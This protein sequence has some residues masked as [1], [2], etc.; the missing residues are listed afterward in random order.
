M[1]SGCSE[2]LSQIPDD[3]GAPKATC[4]AGAFCL[5]VRGTAPPMTRL[6]IVWSPLAA[7]TPPQVAW[8]M[9]LAGGPHVKVQV[10]QIGPPSP[11]RTSC[12]RDC[13]DPARCPCTTPSGI[14]VGYAIAAVDTNGSGKI[15]LDAN[16]SGDALVGAGK[17]VLGWAAE[18]IDPANCRDPGAICAYALKYFPKGMQKGVAAYPVTHPEGGGRDLV[19]APAPL[20]E[21][22][23]DFCAG[24]PCTPDF[25]AIQ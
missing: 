8:E 9:A 18:A 21:Y 3:G 19:G 5:E 12:P 17:V 23:V 20:L 24:S 13:A 1:I 11:D 4:E 7:M 22:P 25:P 14:G 2:P 6:G 15:D 10:A 16:L